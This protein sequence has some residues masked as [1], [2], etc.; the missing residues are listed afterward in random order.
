MLATALAA[1]DR[2]HRVDGLEARL[3]RLAHRLTEDD[4]RSLALQGHVDLLPA[5]VAEAVQRIA[6]RVHDTA[7]ERLAHGNGGDAVGPPDDGPFLQEV[8]RAH[9]DGAHVVGLQVH[10]DGHHAVAAV[11]Q[12]AGLGVVQSV[13]ADDAVADLQDFADLLELEIA[14]DIPELAEQHFGNLRRTRR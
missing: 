13:D 10:H 11:Q 14:L 4:A 5:D 1:A 3:Q 8:G 7:H 9:Q 12:F 2:N 6:E